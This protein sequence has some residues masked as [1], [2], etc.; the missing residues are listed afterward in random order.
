MEVLWLSTRKVEDLS[1]STQQGI[2]T[3]LRNSRMKVK[4]VGPI[5]TPTTNFAD[6]EH[7]QLP[8]RQSWGRR[9]SSFAKHLRDWLEKE[10]I[11]ADVILV[12]WTLVHYVQSS[13]SQL[14]IPKILIDRS[15]PADAGILARLQWRHW[16]TAW[17]AVVSGQIQAGC[18]VSAAHSDLVTSSIGVP[19][20]NIDIL[21]AGV[22]KASQS[23]RILSRPIQ[24]VYHGRL[25]K[26][27]GLQ[28]IFDF[29][30]SAN[31]NGLDLNLTLFGDGNLVA[32]KN[33]MP[34][35]QIHYGGRIEHNKILD[36][37]ER[38]HFGL[39]PMPAT[40]VWSVASPL[41]QNEYLAAGLPILGIDHQGHRLE[42]EYD[43][44]NL[45]SPDQFQSQSMKHL[46]HLT[47][48]NYEMLSQQARTYAQ[49]N[50][51]WEVRCESLLERLK[52][53]QQ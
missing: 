36:E 51:L 52:S 19:R 10:T 33:G 41:K 16:K 26:N 30:K 47:E 28:Q 45:Y 34:S 24:M 17:S 48:S 20:E 1:A 23:N 40:K 37:L 50:C 32:S 8:Q 21:P 7:I 2:V 6:C 3:M 18:V 9:T 46:S 14:N 5:C 12:D 39:L 44:L 4:F 43:F 42:Q 25:D 13:L 22:S 35:K 31:G 11:V 27:R 29:V 53:F 15:P 49:D 38:F